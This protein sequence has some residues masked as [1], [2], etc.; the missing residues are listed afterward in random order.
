LPDLLPVAIVPV[1]LA[2]DAKAVCPTFWIPNLKGIQ[3]L[4]LYSE[5]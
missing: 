5:K 1:W 4:G 2:P 3:L